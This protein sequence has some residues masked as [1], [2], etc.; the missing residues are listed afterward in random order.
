M[1]VFWP[2]QFNPDVCSRKYE[3]CFYMGIGIQIQSSYLQ[4]APKNPDVC[5]HKHESCL[6]VDIE[7][8]CQTHFY[9]GI[10]VQCLYPDV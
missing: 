6:Y 5:R 4:G 10:D 8:K 7:Q 3:T 1:I 2:I 9:V